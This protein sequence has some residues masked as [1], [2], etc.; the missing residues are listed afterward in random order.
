MAQQGEAMADH[1]VASVRETLDD[2]GDSLPVI[3]GMP[4]GNYRK[5]DVVEGYNLSGQ[6]VVILH[7]GETFDPFE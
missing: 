4:D 7:V 1:T 6:P 2:H 5:V 3:I